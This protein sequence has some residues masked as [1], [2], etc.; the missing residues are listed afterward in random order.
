MDTAD[1]SIRRVALYRAHMDLLADYLETRTVGSFVSKEQY[2][3]ASAG[4]R[5]ELA[6]LQAHLSERGSE[7]GFWNIKKDSRW[8]G[9]IVV[10]RSAIEAYEN[11]QV[12]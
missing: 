4:I 10:L 12:R 1:F 2:E 6:D 11:Y 3:N 5:V 7:I 8:I 9:V